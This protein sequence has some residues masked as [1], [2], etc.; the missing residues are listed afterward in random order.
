MLLDR[1]ITVDSGVGIIIAAYSLT[2]CS[3]TGCCVLFVCIGICVLQV[4]YLFGGNPGKDSQPKMRLDD[5]WS[6]KVF[7]ENYFCLSD[8]M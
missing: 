8:G 2:G 7:K 4:H 5:L 6:L 3:Q 1:V